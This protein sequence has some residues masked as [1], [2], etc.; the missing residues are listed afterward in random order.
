MRVVG[1]RWACVIAAV[2][3]VLAITVSVA[4]A[5]RSGLADD[6]GRP[7]GGKLSERVGNHCKGHENRTG[8]VTGL[9]FVGFADV[10]KAS[11]GL[12]RRFEFVDGSL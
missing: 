1:R 12:K 11:A 5:A 3:A 7:V 8:H 6:I 10:D 4:G 2:L 9:V